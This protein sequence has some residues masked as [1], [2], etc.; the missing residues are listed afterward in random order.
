MHQRTTV[1]LTLGLAFLLTLLQPVHGDTIFIDP[2]FTS[3]RTQTDAVYRN[4][5]LRI[6][7]SAT[8]LRYD[9]YEPIQMS[10]G[11]AVPGLR[12]GLMLLHGG[13][14]ATGSKN[15][16]GIEHMAQFFAERGYVVAAINYRLI[17]EG[18]PEFDP[19][20]ESG[21]AAVSP[22]T[23]PAAYVAWATNPAN[24]QMR[25]TSA[26]NAAHNDASIAADLFFNSADALNVD[27][28]RIAVGG[29]SAGAI[30]AL[31]TAYADHP[32]GP[33][34][35]FGAVISLAGGLYGSESVI[36][37]DEP[38]LWFQHAP[39][40]ATVP[41]SN[42]E[43]LMAR[44]DAI[45]LE[46]SFHQHNQGHS[47]FTPYFSNTTSEGLTFAEDSALFL[48]E[49]MEL[50]TI[51]EPATFHVLLGGLVVGVAGRVRRRRV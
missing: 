25:Q 35:D 48:Y 7:G 2:L 45:G 12:P 40:D 20:V 21:P 16:S 30:T 47:T 3:F 17:D 14:F 24:V 50:A 28:G 29:S 51:P 19:A 39:N 34:H 8:S 33:G 27:P 18:E 9:L 10:G 49:Q 15:N 22:P 1:V 11:P 41:F 38:P 42:A 13:G 43:A 44:A 23:D 4:D 36:D 26:A 37:A 32:N 5:A 6:N 31:T 46:Y